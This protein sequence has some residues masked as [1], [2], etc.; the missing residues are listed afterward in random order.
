MTSAY[1]RV[2]EMLKMEK[3]EF[4]AS[5]TP[6]LRFK[7]RLVVGLGTVRSGD[8]GL[9]VAKLED[10]MLALTGCMSVP[11]IPIRRGR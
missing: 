8:I 3:I 9:E 1:D 6:G 10:G 7:D 5:K 4:N 2:S 11:L